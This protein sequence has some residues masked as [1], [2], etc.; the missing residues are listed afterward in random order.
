VI[1]T[2]HVVIGTG[3]VVIGTGHV[4]IGTGHVVIG[5]GLVVIGNGLVAI[6]K[7]FLTGIASFPRILRFRVGFPRPIPALVMFSQAATPAPGG[8]SVPASRKAQS[9]LCL[10]QIR[11]H[12]RSGVY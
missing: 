2:G 7:G 3:H 6:G 1:G 9:G 8:A 4:V 11:T 12:P 5:N 10:E